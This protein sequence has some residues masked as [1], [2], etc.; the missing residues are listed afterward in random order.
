MKRLLDARERRCVSHARERAPRGRSPA[1][2][3]AA[4]RR[5][6]GDVCTG[7]CRSTTGPASISASD[8]GCWLEQHRQYYGQV[9]ARPAPSERQRTPRFLGGGQIGVDYEFGGGVV[10]F[11]AEGYVR[12]AA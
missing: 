5:R 11:G 8:A 4:R 7:A 12:L 10:R 1:S 2:D 3:G 9:D 6:A